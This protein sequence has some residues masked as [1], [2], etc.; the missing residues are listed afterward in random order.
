MLQ[1]YINEIFQIILII[2]G[3][4]VNAGTVQ[5]ED[6]EQSAVAHQR[7]DKLGTRP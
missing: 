4:S 2:G 3:K 6:A 7:Y 5:I 1:K